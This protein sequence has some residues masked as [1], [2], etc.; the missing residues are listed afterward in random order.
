MKKARQMF[1]LPNQPCLLLSFTSSGQDFRE[2]KAEVCTNF[3][4]MKQVTQRPES[5]CTAAEGEVTVFQRRESERRATL[6]AAEDQVSSQLV[7]Q[8]FHKPDHVGGKTASSTYR[9][10]VASGQQRQQSRPLASGAALQV[11]DT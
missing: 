2:Y 1:F 11:T 3:H 5:R 6:D 10:A 9:S 7:S 8:C 4:F